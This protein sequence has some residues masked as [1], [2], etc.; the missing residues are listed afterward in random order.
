MVHSKDHLISHHIQIYD[1]KGFRV[2]KKHFIGN[3]SSFKIN[4]KKFKPGMYL[5]KSKSDNINGVNLGWSLNNHIDFKHYVYI[6]FI[7]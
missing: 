3:L 2:Y 6:D 7:A 5:V 1:A 4:I